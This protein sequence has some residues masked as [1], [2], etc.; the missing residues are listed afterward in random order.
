MNAQFLK[1]NGR[2]L[3]VKSVDYANSAYNDSLI[4]IIIIIYLSNQQPQ[5]SGVSRSLPR[6]DEQDPR[7]VR[8]GLDQKRISLSTTRRSFYLYF[9][10]SFS[11]LV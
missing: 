11:A 7:E 6:T 8:A 4:I 3:H 1:S 9:V 5:H 10:P 2:R